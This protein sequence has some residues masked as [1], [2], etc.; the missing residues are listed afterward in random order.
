[1]A[2]SLGA[3]IDFIKRTGKTEKRLSF[4]EAVHSH[5]M[6]DDRTALLW[7]YAGSEQSIRIDDAVRNLANIDGPLPVNIRIVKTA[8][9]RKTETGIDLLL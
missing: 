4:N 3:R 9:Y 6:P 8:Q 2:R 1:M 5:K 7:L